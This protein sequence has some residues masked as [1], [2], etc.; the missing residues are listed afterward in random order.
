MATVTTNY[1]SSTASTITL[2]SLGADGWRESTG[3]SNAT[4]KYVDIIV[5]GNI[6]VGAVTADGLIEIYVAASIDN[7]TTYSGGLN[8]TD[9]TITWGTTPTSSSVEGF[10][11]L[12]LLDIIAVDTTDDNNPIEFTCRTT[13][14]QACGGVVPQD[15][16]IVVHNDTDIGFHASGTANEVIYVGNWFDVA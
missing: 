6:R 11:N 9:Q 16:S 3:I 5:S 1:D 13:V 12:H 14:A 2:V 4:N 7:G 10:K 8:G 15:W